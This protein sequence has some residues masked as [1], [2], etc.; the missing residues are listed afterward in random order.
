MKVR[1]GDCVL[2][3]ATRQLWRAGRELHLTPKT[4]ELLVHLL[5]H[6]PRACSKEELHKRLW[7]DTYVSDVNLAKA[8]SEVRA[9]IGDVPERPQWIRTLHGYGYA[10]CGATAS[11]SDQPHDSVHSLVWNR[12]A[13]Q[14]APV[15]TCWDAIR[16]LPSGWT[17]IRFRVGTR[18]S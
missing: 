1:F 3:A 8:V 7:P 9:A 6:R 11:E 14:L 13:V 10:F 18:A 17:R 5:D 4:F 15:R 16:P 12:H 2:D